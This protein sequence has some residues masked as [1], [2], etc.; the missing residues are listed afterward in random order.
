MITPEEIIRNVTAEI[1]A[2]NIPHIASAQG[3]VPVDI[4]VSSS[5]PRKYV[6]YYSD[7]EELPSL[8]EPLKVFEGIQKNL[9][10]LIEMGI[11][12][13]PDIKIVRKDPGVLKTFEDNQDINIV[14]VK[15]LGYNSD[16]S[17]KVWYE[18]C[19][20]ENFS[21][22]WN[23]N[24]STR[25]KRGYEVLQNGLLDVK[26]EGIFVNMSATGAS[27]FGTVPMELLSSQLEPFTSSRLMRRLIELGGDPRMKGEDMKRICSELSYD[28]GLLSKT[29]V[30][31]ALASNS[32][33]L[34]LDMDDVMSFNPRGNNCDDCHALERVF[35]YGPLRGVSFYLGQSWNL[36][37]FLDGS[38]IER[39]RE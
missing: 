32:R 19:I 28:E 3:Y 17:G 38:Y 31:H 18:N 1:E 4:Y 12:K 20:S 23:I 35:E 39:F 5:E 26:R 22:N 14:P 15:N 16:V 21:F 33:E 30:K 7:D 8:K 37:E 6:E 24:E 25:Y 10:D 29:I 9:K 36:D 34:G 27:L 2:G 13:T 11:I